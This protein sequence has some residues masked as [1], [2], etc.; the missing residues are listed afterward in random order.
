MLKIRF[1][2]GTENNFRKYDADVITSYDLT[3]DYNS[4]LHYS[5]YAFSVNDEMTIVPL[6]SD[7]C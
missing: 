1:F 2:S 3:Y 4:V 7:L 6:V 5:A